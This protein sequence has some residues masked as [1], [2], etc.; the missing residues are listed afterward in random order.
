MH[1]IALIPA[2]GG[3]KRIPG[4]N[5]QP[6]FEHPLL[7]YAINGALRAGIFQGIYV[8]SDS[9]EIGWLALHYG[10]QWIKRPPEFALDNSPDAEWIGHALQNVPTCD[11]F[12]ILRPTSPFRTPD[13][14][15][16]AW[17]GWDKDH[18]MKGIQRVSEHPG[19]MWMVY[20]DKSL[21][22]HCGIWG[23]HLLPTQNLLPTYVQNGCLEI[24]RAEH[25]GGCKYFW[26]P[27]FT[28]GYEGLDLN[29]PEDW[30]LAEALVERGLVKLPKIEMGLYEISL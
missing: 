16:R 4:K 22:W 15:K 17:Q 26:Q 27:F 8:S 3:S 9:E 23:E 10:A 6:F 2:R 18:C 20:P 7:A 13:T 29:T 24:R 11:C 30:I 21:M 14:I 25:S 5:I 1:L 19:K 12:M 28:E